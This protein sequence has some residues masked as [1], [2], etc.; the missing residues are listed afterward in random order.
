MMALPTFQDY[1]PF[2][3]P[4][5]QLPRRYNN[6]QE[7]QLIKWAA[8][9]PTQTEA[10][11]VDQL[12]QVLDEL[13]LA[14]VD[15]N[16][17]LELAGIVMSAVDRVV[18]TLRHRYCY[19]SGALSDSQLNDLDHIKSLYKASI[20]VYSGIISRATLC[21]AGNLQHP[22][23][24]Q[25]N[26][27]PY[28]TRIKSSPSILGLAI[29]RALST[30]LKILKEITLSYQKPPKNLWLTINQLYYLAC[31][32]NIAHTDLRAVVV[33]H[34]A[35]N[36]HKLYCQVCLHSLLNLP[37]M[38][39]ASILMVHRLLPLWSKHI[40]AT[41]EPQT[42]TRVYVDLHSD[43]PPCYLNAQSVINPYQE[44]YDC[45]FIELA[46]LVTYLQLRSQTLADEG[47]ETAE[48]C[49]LDKVWMAVTYRYIQPQRILPTKQSLKQIASIITE[50][51]AIHYY[52]SG[53]QSLN[54]LLDSEAL[55]E[56]QR[57]R[58]DTEPK[59]NQLTT[60]TD[61]ETFD[62]EDAFSHFRLLRLPI[63]SDDRPLVV[64]KEPSKLKQ[65]S[66]SRIGKQEAKP[67]DVV[68]DEGQSDTMISTAPPRLRNMSL[69][70]LCRLGMTGKDNWSI[71]I[72]RWL[73]F[74]QKGTEVEWQILGN[75]IS[76]C[77]VR[78]EDRSERS[79]SFVPAFLVA[80]DAPLQTS[81]SLLLPR[82]RFQP[83][84]KVAIYI[85]GEQ[86]SLRLQDRLLATT[87][88]FV[89]YEIV[90]L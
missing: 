1:L 16:W 28:L 65:A 49:L 8:L 61:V 71:G 58:Y 89:Q 67:T 72:V 47:Y 60:L 35:G 5:A 52:V 46:P 76:A 44:Q 37:A 40:I 82:A 41:L 55:P 10:A 63:D 43:S 26:W 11:Q 12:L 36:I 77:A 73:G 30:Y 14:N 54:T 23:D 84:D 69:F 74:D 3:D 90:R 34:H 13:T 18:I 78:L 50:F 45:L 39:R 17:R 57:P 25:N 2:K 62:R 27:V 75:D 68:V 51:N 83:N 4:R 48:R 31:D 24:P 88:E 66:T 59:P 29:Y 21:V 53:S 64:D 86:Q 6:L 38:T 87:E 9:L 32:Y 81:S 22:V 33:N 19:E 70:L 85:N 56:S 15:D 20:E 42:E 80:A 79:Q 7:Q